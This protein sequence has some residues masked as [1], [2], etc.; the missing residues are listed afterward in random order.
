LAYYHITPRQLSYVPNTVFAPL[1]PLGTRIRA[2]D[3]GGGGGG[4]I[5]GR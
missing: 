2:D 3:D 5:V 4:G 1:H